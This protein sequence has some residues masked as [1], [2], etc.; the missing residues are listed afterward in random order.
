MSRNAFP[1]R[2]PPDSAIDCG[3]WQMDINGGEAVLP[4]SLPDWDYQTD[5]SLARSIVVDMDAIRIA[6]GLPPSS[7]VAISIVWAATGSNL[8][9]AA[10]RA[11]VFGEGLQKV[12]LAAELRGS[13]LGGVLSLETVLTLATSDV[14]VSSWAPKHAG[15]LLWSDRVEVRLQGD[16]AQFPVAIVDFS[17]TNYPVDAGWFLEVGGS[18]DAATMGSLLLVVNEANTAV[19]A[20]FKNAASPS[21]TDMAVMSAVY[22]DVARTLI[23]HALC[24]LDFEESVEYQDGSIGETLQSLIGMRFH[25]RTVEEL[26][27]TRNNSP[28]LFSAELQA[29]VSVFSG[30]GDT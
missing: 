15:S 11:E 4:E 21:Q 5:L 22:S 2:I 27:N 24:N 23:E 8:R 12:A 18:L 1:Y 7:G 9:A 28:S 30:I 25:G 16:A 17:S 14:A 13:D 19:C 6:T 26:R 3:E 29:A 10:F 20:A